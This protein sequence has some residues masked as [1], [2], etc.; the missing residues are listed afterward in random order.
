M[1][2]EVLIPQP[3]K[4]PCCV[5]INNA[6]GSFQVDLGQL[7]LANNTLI[8]TL[9]PNAI[10]ASGRTALTLAAIQSAA[11]QFRAAIAR[12]I[13]LSE[14]C[15]SP[16]C[17]S[18]AQALKDEAFGTVLLILAA[19]PNPSIPFPGTA[20]FGLAA[21]LVSFV[22]SA[23]FPAGTPGVPAEIPTTLGTL[24]EALNLILSTIDCPPCKEICNPCHNP[25]KKNRSRH[26]NY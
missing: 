23:T 2:D 19:A 18:A 26:T 17:S 6:I 8:S 13:A 14:R 10:V 9:F 21:V 25:C 15:D 12:L 7:L 5:A 16:C 20:T 3:V 1:S 24:N 22:G 4:I 11:A